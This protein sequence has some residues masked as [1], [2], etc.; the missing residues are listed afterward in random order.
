M[1][2]ISLAVSLGEF[3]MLKQ[4]NVSK[5]GTAMEIKKIIEKAYNKYKCLQSEDFY[6]SFDEQHNIFVID[7]HTFMD[8][9]INMNRVRNVAKFVRKYSDFP[10]Y[11]SYGLMNI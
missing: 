3:S 8:G 1:V 7:W 4:N 11:N 9:Y 10:I 2:E 5:E 6:L